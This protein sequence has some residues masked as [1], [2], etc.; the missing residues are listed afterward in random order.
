L[1][2][3]LCTDDFAGHLAHNANL[4]LKAILGLGVYAQMAQGWGYAAGGQ[5]SRQAAEAMADRWIGLADDGDH[6]RLVF[7]QPR[8]WSQKYSLVWDKLLGLNLF[9]P[10]V[11]R[12]EVAYYLTKQN[13]YGLPLDSRSDYTK[14]DWITWSACLAENRSDFEALIAPLLRYTAESTSRVPLSDW[15]WTTTGAHGAFQ[16]RSVVGVVFLKVFQE[17][18]GDNAHSRTR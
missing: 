2:G 18:G 11:A 8:T 10:E 1:A 16:A 17:S 13:R 6:S 3:G 12:R 14:L 7:D 5:T 15:Y 4:S 9:A